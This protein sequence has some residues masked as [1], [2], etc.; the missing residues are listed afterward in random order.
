MG[1]LLPLLGSALGEMLRG[2]G[3]VSEFHSDSSAARQ[4]ML[5]QPPELAVLDFPEGSPCGLDLLR[6]A[7]TAGI[8]TRLVLIC[9]EADG[10]APL[11]AVE[12]GVDGLLLR[13]APLDTVAHCITTVVRGEQWLD[14]RAMRAAYER[15]ARRQSATPTLLTRRERDVARLVAAGQRNRVIAEK[16]GISEGTVKMHLHNVYAKMGLESRTQLAMDVRMREIA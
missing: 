3:F 16:L 2:N 6:D 9:N 10:D 4:S 11:D 15:M 7:R 14:T 1:S 5:T 8:P 13:S 12:L